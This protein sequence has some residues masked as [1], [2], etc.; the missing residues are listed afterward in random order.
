MRSLAAST[1]SSEPR[2]LEAEKK[3][4][5]AKNGKNASIEVSPE[6]LG[7]VLRA[8]LMP[9]HP[10]TQRLGRFRVLI[11]SF[12]ASGLSQVPDLAVTA[13][14]TVVSAAWRS[15]PPRPAGS[16][17]DARRNSPDAPAPRCAPPGVP[18]LGNKAADSS[19]S[20]TPTRSAA[21]KP[22]SHA[23]TDLS[24]GSSFP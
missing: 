23:T 16:P 4:E 10:P 2:P 14:D 13:P 5:C 3:S 24:A 9:A 8:H 11:L 20:R 6:A 17:D 21:R 19:R 7:R 12:L 15:G 18:A 1:K 22:Q